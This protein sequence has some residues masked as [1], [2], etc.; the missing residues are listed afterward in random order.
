MIETVNK[1]TNRTRT[2][3]ARITAAPPTQATA[4]RTAGGAA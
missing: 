3:T 2:A 1:H 4:I